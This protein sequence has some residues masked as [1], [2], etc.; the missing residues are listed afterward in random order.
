VL[1]AGVG[2]IAFGV[3]AFLTYGNT[4]H[5]GSTAAQVR[6]WVQGTGLGQSI[7]TL[8]ADTARV[9]LAVSEH[10]GASV[11][12]TDC[13][14]LA[15]DAEQANGELPTPDGELT[16]LLSSGYTFAYDAG[17][18]CYASGGT[19]QH[20]LE[21]ADRERIKAEADLDQAVQLVNQL[22]HRTLSTTTTT[23]PDEGG[24]FG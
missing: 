9:R 24:I 7:G 11:L 20:L 14:V 22:T 8:V 1:A 18:D 16:N 6:S 12:H 13:G 5:S 2:V 19:N 21:R 4:Q 3:L 15:T 23:Q 10:K 17:N